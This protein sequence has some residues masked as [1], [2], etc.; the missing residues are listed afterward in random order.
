[1]VRPRLSITKWFTKS[2]VSAVVLSVA[3]GSLLYATSSAAGNAALSMSPS[4]TT[5]TVGDD[6]SVSLYLNTNGTGVNAVDAFVNYPTTGT[7]SYSRV[8]NNGVFTGPQVTSPGSGNVEIAR[9]LANNAT[10]TGSQQLVDT[11]H[12]TALSAGSVTLS[13][14]G[15]TEVDDASNA[16]VTGSTTGTTF[17][18]QAAASGGGGGT[19]GGTTTTTTG[20]SGPVAATPASHSKSTSVSVSSKAASTPVTVSNNGTAQ[21]SQPVDVQPTTIQTQ[22]VTSVEYY[23]D[24]KLVATE[25]QA[26][27]TYH[28]DTTQVTNGSHTLVTKTTYANG[29]NKS[30]TQHL[31]V[32]DG[33]KKSSTAIVWIIPPLII[34]LV[35]LAALLYIRFIHFGLRRFSQGPMPAGAGAGVVGTGGTIT[36]SPPDTNTP[37]K[38]TL[39]DLL[40]NT[41]PNNTPPPSSVVTPNQPSDPDHH[42]DS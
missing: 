32:T 1:M 3:V 42:D 4:K 30:S 19:T 29:T 14:G 25:T 31:L 35:G 24:G 33:I 13:Y 36:T 18:I 38:S 17:T 20:T 27:Y 39:E 5:Y 6:I 2:L 12:F 16:N 40:S 34:I 9:T 7:V 28:L 37:S 8:D 41:H 15:S 11:V 10:T 21:V 26:P 23:L 22:G